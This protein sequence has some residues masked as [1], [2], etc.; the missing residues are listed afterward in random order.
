MSHF[1]QV[2]ENINQSHIELSSSEKYN[3]IIE[4]YKMIIIKL[5]ISSE[6]TLYKICSTNNLTHNLN[7]DSVYDHINMFIQRLLLDITQEN[8][9]PDIQDLITKISVLTNDKKNIVYDKIFFLINNF[10]LNFDRQNL[11]C[12]DFEK[13]KKYIIKNISVFLKNN[14]LPIIN[15]MKECEYTWEGEYYLS[16]LDESNNAKNDE[17][18]EDSSDEESSDKDPSDKITNN[19]NNIDSDSDDKITNNHN[20]ESDSDS[21]SDSDYGSNVRF[22]KNNNDDAL[23]DETDNDTISD[24][25]MTSETDDKEYYH[26]TDES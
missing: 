7:N 10:Y 16:I 9:T 21:D 11:P 26:S 24:D 1:N 20:I 18:E 17:K 4:L 6:S 15:V 3:E 13:Y 22:I 25:E 2:L 5:I 23:D 19:H 14:I 12:N 8:C